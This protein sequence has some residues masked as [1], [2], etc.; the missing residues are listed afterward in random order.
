VKIISKE[1]IVDATPGQLWQTWTTSEGLTS[2]F[3]P[4][5]RI[6]LKLFGPFE[7]FFL[8]GNPVG[9]QGSEGCMVLSFIPNQMLS[10]TWNSPP[11]LPLA[12]KEY[13]IV[14]VQFF[15]VNP[16]K[17]KVVLT[18]HGY[19]VGAEFDLSFQ[20]FEKAWDQVLQNLQK[21][22]SKKKGKISETTDAV[23]S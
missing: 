3:A 5:A 15:S 7:L 14:V 17:T 2:F 1:I 6:E 23:K 10:F 8:P 11:H 21:K 18:N 13:T 19:K 9:E 12:R 22:Y 20:Y 16:G 4:K